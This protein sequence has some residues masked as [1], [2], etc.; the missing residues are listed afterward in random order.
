MEVGLSNACLSFEAAG[1]GGS[2]PSHH[3]SSMG[4]LFGGCATRGRAEPASVEYRLP[5][6]CLSAGK[7]ALRTIFCKTPVAPSRL[8]RR[9]EH[10]E[11]S[12][13]KYRWLFSGLCAQ[14]GGQQPEPASF[15]YPSPFWGLWR[16]RAIK[17][18]ERPSKF[19]MAGA[20]FLASSAH[21]NPCYRKVLFVWIRDHESRRGGFQTTCAHVRHIWI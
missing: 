18:Q 19:C 6:R 5:L 3:V 8:W 21:L 9:R 11:P 14:G 2:T 17:K 16:V 10:A 1:E 12:S 15:K 7:R 13:V 20:P 4:F